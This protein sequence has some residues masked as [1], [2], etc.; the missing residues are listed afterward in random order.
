MTERWERTKEILDR[1]LQLA[2]EGRREY[3]EQACGS[4]GELRAE[5]E[6]LIASDAQADSQFLAAAAPALL[7]I[8]DSGGGS[9]SPAIIVNQVIGH[10]R[11]VEE[12]GRGGM[13]VVYK[14]EDT[15]LRRLVALKFLPEEVV[16]DAQAL[17]R[18]RREAQAASALNHPNICTVYDIGETSGRGYIVLEFLEGATLNHRIAGRPLALDSLLTLAIEVADALEAVHGRGLV[19]R[20][21]KPA[22]IFVTERGHA[23]VLDFGLA[24]SGAGAGSP[25][26]QATAVTKDITNRHLSAPGLAIGTAAYMSPEQVLGRE[27]DGRTDLFSLGVV[28][29]EMA[30]GALPFSGHGTM[31]LFDSVLHGVPAPPRQINAEVPPELEH[32]IHKALEKDKD[33]R[34]Q[35]AAEIR[36]DLQRLRRDTQTATAGVQGVRTMSR[37]RMRWWGLTAAALAVA[38]VT[39]VA[40]LPR[41]AKPLTDKD[42]VVLA[43]LSNSTGDPVF[44][45]TL[46]TALTISLNQSP[47]LNV[48]P[49]QKVAAM[50]KLMT[51]P[52]DTKLTPD[53]AREVCQR[54]GSKAYLAAS[55]AGLGREYVVELKAVNCQSGDLLAQEQV[56]ASSKEKV[57][58]ALGAA[59]SNLRRKLGESLASVRKFDVPLSEATTPSLEAL[60]AFTTGNIVRNTRGDTIAIQYHQRAIELDPQFALAYLAAGVDYSNLGESARAAEYYTKAFQLR[61]RASDRERLIIAG[62]YYETVNGDLENAA[63]TFQEW[64]ANYPRSSD[65]RINLASVY[66]LEGRYEE[67]AE[68]TREGLEIEPDINTAYTG[69]AT[70]LIALQRYD[71]AQKVLLGRHDRNLAGADI[72]LHFSLYDLAFLRGDSAG[73]AQ[74]SNWFLGKPGENLGL[75]LASDSE[76]YTGRLSQA[77]ELTRRS[78]AS[79]VRADSKETGAFALEISA[80]REAA[81]GNAVEAKQAA[82]E[83][84]RLAPGS[85]AVEAEAAF[86]LAMAGDEAR[87][88]SLAGELNRRRPL[89]TQIQVLWLP[90]I[91]ATLALHHKDA[92]SAINRLEVA[93]PPIEYGAITSNNAISC[94][95]PTY[96]RAQAYLAAGRGKEAAAEFQ[97][98]LDH[99][100]LVWNCWTGALARLGVARANALQAKNSTAGDADAA[101][102]RAR[103]AYANFLTLWKDADP[104]IPILKKAKAEY[105]SLN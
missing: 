60:K 8:G 89:D 39:V 57:L 49:D 64:K 75:S 45:D 19:H 69:L 68:V 21:I 51:Q 9:G 5:V 12:I 78:V 15:R 40:L 43:D 105:A 63:Q 85:P 80:T 87:A 58:D 42:T 22:N 11:V 6:S 88:E 37:R 73:M 79:A 81:F 90:A 31:E 72:A 74:Q 102:T 29:Y 16:R 86:A 52:P 48:L 91:R 54:S 35:H 66:S 94:L 33:L 97:R 3:L 83:G 65:S 32:I 95:F 30:T 1:A 38:A 46:K 20:D 17:A 4:D 96:V 26:E 10:Y 77:R 59:A 82:E 41:R 99:S 76:A 104:D 44:D 13:G 14:G 62:F 98:I 24:K 71:E 103:A 93:V 27:L 7:K 18:F 25:A 84:L 56:T 34:Y 70:F 101:R 50:L 67:A 36:A 92:T 2:P 100:G 47:F 53:T 23:K 55:L 28:L 61:E